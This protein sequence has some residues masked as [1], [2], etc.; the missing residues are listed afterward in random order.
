MTDVLEGNRSAEEVRARVLVEKKTVIN[1]LEAF[2]VAVKHYLRGEDG[3]HY[4]DLYHLVKH[5]PAYAL[6]AG[7]P[8]QANLGDADE[9]VLSP[10]R[11]KEEHGHDLARV[12]SRTSSNHS[13]PLPS[14]ARGAGRP[15]KQ[16][17]VSNRSQHAA[18]RSPVS[19]RF[20]SSP[21]A[22]PLDDGLLMPARMPPK[23]GLFD[24]F[25]FSLLVR[26][27][28]KRGKE[29][30]GKKAARLRAKRRGKESSH[31]IPLEVSLYLVG[32]AFIKL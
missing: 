1:L 9:D 17:V 27:L 2:G 15:R 16:S 6:P 23:Y 3:I 28:E 5:L 14:T 31:N 22:G 13:L 21:S 25:P 32:L 26:S 10:L 18:L 11:E 20:P 12:T 4:V 8:S 29:L 30:A 7:I 19:G 24:L